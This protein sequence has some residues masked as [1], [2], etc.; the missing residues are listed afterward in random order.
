M[1]CKP[2]GWSIW[3]WWVLANVLGGAIP[4]VVLEWIFWHGLPGDLEAVLFWLLLLCLAALSTGIA[5]WLVLR[6]LLPQAGRWIGATF[7]GIL[8]GALVT[9]VA[10]GPVHSLTGQKMVLEA[11][12]GLAV[13]GAVVG[14]M[15]FVIL[16]DGVLDAY[17]WVPASATAAAARGAVFLAVAGIEGLSS[18]L[19]GTEGWLAAWAV[20]GAVTGGALG[21][22]LR[23][24]T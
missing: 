15:Q 21:L 11:M 8:L 3:L 13:C 7:G 5:Q 14:W 24:A 16:H 1:E 22:L 20:Y 6:R 4:W 2:V 17:W 10:A 12:I 18:G 9:G 19:G 23:Q